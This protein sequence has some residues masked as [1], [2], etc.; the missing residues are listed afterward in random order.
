MKTKPEH[1]VLSLPAIVRRQGRRMQFPALLT[2]P[3]ATI[4]EGGSIL[5]ECLLVNR[6]PVAYRQLSNAIQYLKLS[7]P[8]RKYALRTVVPDLENGLKVESLGVWRV[9]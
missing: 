1:N 4:L 2:L 3:V 6:G 9:G 7:H 8:E 5:G